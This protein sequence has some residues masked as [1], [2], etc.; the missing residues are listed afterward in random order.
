MTTASI[1]TLI[2]QLSRLP[3]LGPRSGRR[4]ALHLMKNRTTLLQPLMQTLGQVDAEV[5]TCEICGNLD[6]TPQ[7]AICINTK[8]DQR[9]LC[10]VADV[11]DLWALE[12]GGA[13]QGYYHVLGGILSALD[14]VQPENLRLPSLMARAPAFEEIIIALN[15]TVEGQTTAHYIQEKLK[16]FQGKIT[17]L[18]HG[19][20]VGGELDYL[21]DGTLYMALNARVPL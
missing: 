9:Y 1:Q 18:A 6:V 11:D 12:R 20:P 17:R 4:L 13:F 5:K 15:A 7:C 2:K 3:G 21:D 16:S 10:V 14:G 19:L 8:R